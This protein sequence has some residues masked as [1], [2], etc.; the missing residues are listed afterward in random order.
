MSGLQILRKITIKTCGDFKLKKVKE[1]VASLKEGESKPI[2]KVSGECINAKTGQTAMGAFTRLTGNFVGVDL[3]TGEMYQS[4]E[5]I[6]PDYVGA[7]LGAAILGA[8]GK[9]VNFAFE[10]LAQRVDNAIAGFA[11]QIKPIGDVSISESQKRLLA[12]LGVDADAPKQ[13][14]G[15]SENTDETDAAAKAG[16]SAPAPAPAEAAG[17]KA[18]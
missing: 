15:E 3:T 8:N 2:I 11:Y 18:K 6:L 13:I 4:G 9:S 16:A 5:C 14:A 7:Q 17:K 10:I 12:M 1:I